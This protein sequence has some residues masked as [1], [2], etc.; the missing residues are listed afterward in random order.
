MG[1][2]AHASGGC[3][4]YVSGK[5][6]QFMPRSDNMKILIVD[7]QTA[8]RSQM[9]KIFSDLDSEFVESADGM[10]AVE[11]FLRDRPDLVL[12]DIRMPRMNGF[13]ALQRIRGLDASAPVVIVTQYD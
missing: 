1:N 2:V 8:S 6:H 11:A 12:M 5:H 10:E 7:D 3:A 9:K 13:E 4:P